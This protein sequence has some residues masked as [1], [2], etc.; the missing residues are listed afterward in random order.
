MSEGD[1]LCLAVGTPILLSESNVAKD[2]TEGQ[3]Q[4]MQGDHL[5]FNGPDPEEDGGDPSD[6]VPCVKCGQPIPSARLKAKPDAVRCARCQTLVEQDA[7]YHQYIDEGLAGTREA[8]KRMRGQDW[9]D[10]RK[11]GRE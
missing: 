7:D 4:S 3:T 9:S 1:S 6:I 8:H 11:R 2:H 5:G 10:M